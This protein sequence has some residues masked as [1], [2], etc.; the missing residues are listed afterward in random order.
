MKSSNPMNI[1]SMLL[2]LFS[3]PAFNLIDFIDFGLHLLANTLSN[4]Y[5]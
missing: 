4:L 3:L 1:N 2:F 5:I